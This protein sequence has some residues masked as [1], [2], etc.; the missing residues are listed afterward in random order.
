MIESETLLHLIT[1]S[2]SPAVMISGTSMLV[3]AFL[4]RQGVLAGRLREL[5]DKALQHAEIFHETKNTFHA[6]RS[7]MYMKQAHAIS[8]R[9]RLVKWTL[10]FQFIAII[11]LL[12]STMCLGLGT[13]A[14]EA[15]LCAAVLLVAGVLS[16]F[17][18]ALL[19][20]RGA[21]KS[22]APLEREQAETEKLLARIGG[23]SDNRS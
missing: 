19:A 1:A 22:M 17:A 12:L 20:L 11:L 18:S 4:S 16:L 9:A 8:R 21:L 6:E 7:A 2:V 13:F 5:H 3:L 10:A 23:I 14:K 15:L